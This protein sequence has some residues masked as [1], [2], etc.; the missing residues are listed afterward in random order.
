[1]CCIKKKKKTEK[2]SGLFI[3]SFLSFNQ[4]SETP[5]NSY[6]CKKKE[7]QENEQIKQ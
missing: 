3:I 5:I 4:T 1:M 7:K 6:T 2:A